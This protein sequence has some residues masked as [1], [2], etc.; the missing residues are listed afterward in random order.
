VLYA[1]VGIMAS[2]HHFNVRLS[3]DPQTMKAHHDPL[4]FSIGIATCSPRLLTVLQA[5]MTI[6]CSSSRLCIG[7]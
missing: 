3:G 2:L 5:A 6:R 4:E 7:S 1:V